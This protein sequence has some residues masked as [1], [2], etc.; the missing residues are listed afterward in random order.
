AAV[1]AAYPDSTAARLVAWIQTSRSSRR[2]CHSDS[3]KAAASWVLPD[4]LSQ[5]RAAGSPAG[6]GHAPRRGTTAPAPP[7]RSTAVRSGAVSSRSVKP[8][9]TVGTVPDRTGQDGPP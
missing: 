9:A 6:P 1:A 4:D 2:E 3:A 5:S 7:A 8:S